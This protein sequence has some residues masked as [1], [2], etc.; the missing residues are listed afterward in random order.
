MSPNLSM[1]ASF[2]SSSSH[3]LAVL[4]KSLL[5]DV[6]LGFRRPPA[7][8]LEA[9]V[10]VRSSS[11]GSVGIACES[12]ERVIGRRTG[13][14]P[15]QVPFNKGEH[16]LRLLGQSSLESLRA[17]CTTHNLSQLGSRHE[18]MATIV[19]HIQGDG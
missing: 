8:D 13:P 19:A 4:R 1:S 15:P 7:P 10:V 12:F 11:S 18:I 3:S 9:P 6:P 2:D 5:T 16:M 14:T 17:F